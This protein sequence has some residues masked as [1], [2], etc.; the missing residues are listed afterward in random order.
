MT[1]LAMQMLVFLVLA[2]LLG[3]GVGWWLG[4]GRRRV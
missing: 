3:L 1:Y 4:R 2:F